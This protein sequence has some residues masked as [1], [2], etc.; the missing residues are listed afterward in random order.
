VM[1]GLELRKGTLDIVINDASPDI[2][3]QL[4][5]DPALQAIEAPGADYQYIGLNLTDPLLRDVRVRQ[6]LALAIDRQAIVDHLRRGLAVPA[7][8]MLPPISWAVAPDI[9]E[10]PYDPA[11]ARALLDLAGHVDPDGDGPLPRFTLTLKASNIEFNRLQAAVIQ[12]NLR[13]IGIELDVRSYEFATLFA[14][15]LAGNFQLY[16]LQWTSGSLADPDILRR[17]FHTNQVPPAGFNRGRYSNP[18]VDDLLDRAAGEPDDAVRLE[19]YHR[20]QRVLAR[21][22]P[23][24]SVWHKTNVAVAR[25]SLSGVTISPLANLV[26]LRNVA[27]ISSA[28]N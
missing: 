19:L 2:V 24:I 14:D 7:R 17:A 8:G 5:N 4:K 12:Q 23:Y 16:F 27:R 11:R 3:V 26:F 13:G 28:T 20:V 22:L 6:A 25:R 10:Y 1:R 15:V 9:D 21:D 18:E